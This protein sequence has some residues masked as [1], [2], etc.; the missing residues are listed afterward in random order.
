[1]D[2]T[3]KKNLRL[4]L[5]YILGP[6]LFVWLSMNIWNQLAAQPDLPA[7]IEKLKAN[8]IGAGKWELGA[9]L[10]MMVL[11]WG[12]EAVKW[13]TLIA[14]I[15]T[16]GYGRA[17]RAVFSGQALALGTPNRVGEF[18]GR[19]VYLDDGN[20]LRALSLSAVGSLAQLLVTFVMG[21]A[22]MAYLLLLVTNEKTTA[23]TMMP[24]WIEGL[25][26]I[27][28]VSV[29]GMSLLY[30]NLAWAVGVIGKLPWA[31]NYAFFFH[32]LETLHW[33]E[34]SKVLAISFGRYFVYSIQY[35]LMYRFFGITAGWWQILLLTFAQLFVMAIVP[36]IALAEMGIRGK[37][38]IALMG[39]V[40]ENVFGVVATAVSIWLINLIVPAL[41][42]S[43]LVLGVRVFKK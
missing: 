15:Q 19:V 2:T 3:L 29:A 31:S 32:K 8:F 24:Y 23:Q 4:F 20:R 16:I 11:N 38:A 27:I 18:V 33:K 1:M 10:V 21:L 40:S 36:S 43:L 17:F 42:G 5:N 25:M 35:L 37:V 30:F 12:M 7:S 34:L 39:H 41:M 13:R 28:A 9:V 26:S 6:A 14:P 22:G